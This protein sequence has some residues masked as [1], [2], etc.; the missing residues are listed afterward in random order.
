MK[1]S[2][3]SS[4]VTVKPEGGGARGKI[5]AIVDCPLSPALSMDTIL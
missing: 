4:Y 5:I 2:K 1:F 3:Y